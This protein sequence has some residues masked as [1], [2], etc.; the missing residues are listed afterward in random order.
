M[1][2]GARS[3]ICGRSCRQAPTSLRCVWTFPR[4]RRH[5][6]AAR[7]ACVHRR[8]RAGAAPAGRARRR[9]PRP[10]PPRR[11]TRPAAQRSEPSQRGEEEEES[12]GAARAKRAG[13]A[14]RQAGRRAAQAGSGG[15]QEWRAGGARPQ[16]QLPMCTQQ[17]PKSKFS[18]GAVRDACT[19]RVPRGRAPPTP[20]RPRWQESAH[21]GGPAGAPRHSRRGLCRAAAA[22]A[23]RTR[24]ASLA[25][26][27]EQ[28]AAY[29]RRGHAV[30]RQLRAGRLP[31]GSSAC[32][33]AGAAVS[34]RCGARRGCNPACGSSTDALAHG[35]W[36]PPEAYR[37]SAALRPVVT[38]ARLLRRRQLAGGPCAGA[39][40]HVRTAIMSLLW[41][42]VRVRRRQV[43][44]DSA[45]ASAADCVRCASPA[46]RHQ[47][48]RQRRL[49]AF[50]VDAPQTLAC[51]ARRQSRCCDTLH[52]RRLAA[53]SGS[54][55]SAHC[56]TKPRDGLGSRRGWCAAV[57]PGDAGSDADSSRRAQKIPLAPLA[58]VAHTPSL[59]APAA[60]VAQCC[61]EQHASRARRR[62]AVQYRAPY[63]SADGRH[64]CACAAP[65]V[66]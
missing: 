17:L 16:A 2:V 55:A 60:A 56:G 62:A 40:G 61:A 53:A 65:R 47:R 6:R 54:F 52:G 48:V 9:R 44:H 30:T 57:A 66:R 10:W 21:V 25:T 26:P 18:D 24:H 43:D 39:A 15:R 20:P 31:R 42:A 29:R 1:P 32:A 51:Q 64:A 58:H 19:T 34:R 3:A 22:P 14:G 46:N 5:S 11:R 4:S 23:A 8:A 45:S 28:L 37:P 36:R 33:A 13:G 59:A 41:T 12:G 49:A 50:A 35:S 27:Q 7:S 38:R 63:D